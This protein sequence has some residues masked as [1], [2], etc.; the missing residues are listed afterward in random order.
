[1]NARKGLNV[2]E[3][4]FSQKNTP[5]HPDGWRCFIVEPTGEKV[6][7]RY[8]A[9]HDEWHLVDVFRA[10]DGTQTWPYGTLPIGAMFYV[11]NPARPGEDKRSLVVVT[12]VGE[13][14]VDVTRPDGGR[15]QRTGIPPLI[16]LRPQ[17]KLDGYRGRLEGGVL[18]V[19]L[20]G[21]VY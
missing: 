8:G 20:D 10:V 13:V 12:P 16:T 7:V 2:A 11:F 4:Q 19:D 21:R 14:Q 15:W 17:I 3:E 9:A 5:D 6:Q 1:V 18:S